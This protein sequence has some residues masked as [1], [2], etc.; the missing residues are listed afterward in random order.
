MKLRKVLGVLLVGGLLLGL[1]SAWGLP[2]PSAASTSSCKEVWDH[3]VDEK[4]WSSEVLVWAGAHAKVLICHS[5]FVRI[6]PD[7]NP[8]SPNLVAVAQGVQLTGRAKVTEID[9]DWKWA[10]S[11]VEYIDPD[12]GKKARVYARIPHYWPPG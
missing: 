2:V 11:L 8:K 10:Y 3:D 4:S 1:V 12:T 7:Q 9:P 6:I 5:R